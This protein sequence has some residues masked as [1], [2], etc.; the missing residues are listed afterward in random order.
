MIGHNSFRLNEATMIE[1]VQEWLDKRMP[2]EKQRVVAI[3]VEHSSSCKTFEINLETK[4]E[5][6]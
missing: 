4:K 3:E 2:G 1:A 6:K 5:D